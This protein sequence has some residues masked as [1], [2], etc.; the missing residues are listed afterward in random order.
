MALGEVFVA[1]CT[2][3]DA[4]LAILGLFAAVAAET[5]G[6]LFADTLANSCT[7]L[8][9]QLLDAFRVTPMVQTFAVLPAAALVTSF[10]L[11][12]A[13]GARALAL[14]AFVYAL[15]AFALVSFVALRFA[16]PGMLFASLLPGSGTLGV[17]FFAGVATN[18][19]L[20]F[21]AG[22][23]T[24]F[25]CGA[26]LRF[27]CLHTMV[28]VIF[29]VLF[30]TA[31]VAFRASMTFDKFAGLLLLFAF[32]SAL[33]AF[34]FAFAL[35]ALLV[36][37]FAFAF[38]FAFALFGLLFPFSTPDRAIQFKEAFWSWFFRFGNRLFRS[39]SFLWSCFVRVSVNFFK[40]SV[41]VS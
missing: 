23:G 39:S 13:R 21:V 33:L 28:L 41:S 11:G 16:R 7:L 14:D 15:V 17:A 37:A 38:A 27:A 5:G 4:A 30:A 19:H 8:G 20:A 10:A 25:L 40:I 1:L 22:R 31:M 24:N 32:A 18:L 35:L 9:T 36:L 12:T 3:H 34:A 29:A 6:D 26:F 2:M